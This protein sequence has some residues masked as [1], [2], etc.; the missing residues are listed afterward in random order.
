MKTV[1]EKCFSRVL[2]ILLCSIA[3][4]TA[5]SI[6]VLA[7]EK[8]VED[9][10]KANES[11]YLTEGRGEINVL[12]FGAV[13][14]DGID[15]TEAFN[16]AI[17][18]ANGYKKGGC[19]NVPAGVFDIN[20]NVGIY[21]MGCSRVELSMDK[22]THL[23][24]APTNLENYA[25]FHVSLSKHVYIH[26]GS[27]DGERN[28][29]IG[30]EGEYGMGIDILSCKDVTIANMTIQENWGDGIHIDAH[31]GYEGCDGVRIVNCTI[32]NNRRSNISVV[33]AD[34]LTI[35][36][37]YIAYAKGVAPQ[38][39][40]NI[41]PDADGYQQVPYDKVCSNIEILNTTV[42]TCGMGDRYGQYFCFMNHYNP[43]LHSRHTC[44]NVE[45]RNCRFNGDCGNYSGT[46][47]RFYN[48]SIAGTFYDIQNTRLYDTSYGGFWSDYDGND[49]SNC[50]NKPLGKTG[51]F[52]EDG[53]KILYK[54]GCTCLDYSGL[55]KDAQG[56]YWMIENGI[57][58]EEIP[59]AEPQPE[60][61]LAWE[62]IDGKS[63][64]YENGVAQGTYDDPK[65]V[66]GDG[67]V[68]GREI[69]D[70]ESD[71]WYWLDAC[72]GG[73]KACNKEV[74]MPYIYQN[75]KNWDDAEIEANANNSGSMK[76]QVIEYINKG[77]GK[78]VRYDADGKMYKGWYTVKEEDEE[79]YPNQVGNTYYYDF[80]TGL[81]AKGWQTIDGVEYY[82]DETTGVLQ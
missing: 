41:E 70:P 60:L 10:L 49:S 26:G 30:S 24:V 52:E 71:G 39:G 46:N 7:E 27:I 20:P 29:H 74:W 53:E 6:S 75:E 61:N 78:W 72:Y 48:T 64:W 32:K 42:D 63:F 59:Y 50:V 8:K 35:D 67:T 11:S 81:M 55:Y 25:V 3:L 4:A 1:V 34:N 43:Y 47:V 62:T 79:Y 80:Q 54:N 58:E 33:D 65:G 14:G 22:D 31:N 77:Y 9:F 40:I 19:V 73:A 15:D 5:C 51:V 37:C 56:K 18:A 2:M 21:I 36:G 57:V 68:R 45:I 16:K 23:A 82:F 17:N 12:D 69:F 76:Q 44:D 66:I 28:R 13:P 38:C